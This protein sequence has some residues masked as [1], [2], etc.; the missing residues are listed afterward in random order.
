M[1]SLL[2]SSVNSLAKGEGA[3]SLACDAPLRKRGKEHLQLRSTLVKKQ[4]RSPTVP[5][6]GETHCNTHSAQPSKMGKVSVGAGQSSA[7]SAEEA[8][9]G[10]VSQRNVG[11]VGV[12][13][14]QRP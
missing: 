2:A 1:D 5:Q 14:M 9:V 8:L 7:L 13:V 3:I 10:P 6:P 11:G 4:V 12:V